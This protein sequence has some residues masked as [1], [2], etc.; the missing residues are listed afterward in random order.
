MFSVKD[1]GSVYLTD[2]YVN[3][4]LEFPIH[5]C[6]QIEESMELFTETT[7]NKMCLSSLYVM[8]HMNLAKDWFNTDYKLPFYRIYTVNSLRL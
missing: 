3:T 4:L 6:S 5:L 7:E 2:G 1:N 8:Q